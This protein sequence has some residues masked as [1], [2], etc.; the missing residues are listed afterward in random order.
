MARINLSLA[1]WVTRHPL[2]VILLFTVAAS[3]G[4]KYSIDHLRVDTDTAKMLSDELPFKQNLKRFEQLFPHDVNVILIALESSLPEVTETAT[5]RLGN[6]LSEKKKTI[7]SIYLPGEDPFFDRQGLLYLDKEQLQTLAD[8]LARAQPFIAKLYEDFSLGSF[9]QLLAK[10]L[11]LSEQQLPL[12]ITPML[13]EIRTAIEAAA[14][15]RPHLISWQKLM[16]NTKEGV[17]TTTRFVMVSPVL[18]FS[19]L[20]PA[21]EAIRTIH[22]AV[23]QISEI[24][25]IKVT[26]L[27]TGEPVLEHEEMT[28][29]THGTEWAGLVSMILICLS[30]VIG[31]RSVKL[32][33]ATL[34]T[35]VFG[36]IFSVT[37]AAFAVGSLN[38]I[39]IAFAVLYIGLGVDYATHLGLRYRE[40]ILEDTHFF[41][42][43]LH[44]LR[45]VS[46]S[47]MLCALTTALGMYAFIPTA[48][49]GISEL[50]IIA[51]T[52]MFIAVTVTLLLMPALL[53]LMPLKSAARWKQKSTLFFPP[54]LAA[55]PSRHATLIRS[56]A[57]L[58]CIAALGLL[59]GIQ[60]DFNPINLRDPNSESVIAFKK[61]LKGK[62]TS[63]MYL[64][65]LGENEAEVRL[66]K[67]RFES[68]EVVE[69][70]LSIFDFVPTEQDD[71]LAIIDE[72]ALLLG[73]QLEQPLQ[74]RPK[75]NQLPALQDFKR[76]LETALEKS[77]GDQKIAVEKLDLALDLFLQQCSKMDDA[78]CGK[79]VGRLQFSILGTFPRT[80]DKLRLGL[81]ASPFGLADLPES[82][83]E[84]WLSP[85]GI[86]RLDIY[87]AKDLNLLDN[88]REFATQVRAIYPS[89]T[90]LP[91]IYMDSMD[92][93]IDAFKQAFAMAVALITA[94]LFVLLRNGRDVFLVLLP[95]V[96]ASI[97]TGATTVLIGLPFNFANIIALPLL[98]GL[99]VDNGIHVVHRI[100]Q[101]SNPSMVLTTSTARGIFF[102]ALTTL[103]SFTSLAFISHKGVASMGQLLAI[104]VAWTLICTFFVL[105]AFVKPVQSNKEQST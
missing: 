68:L 66:L 4:L 39:S 92:A 105:P 80:L 54:D 51:G 33:L 32:M 27:I 44:S 6:I 38:M 67:N 91:V 49:K 10:A 64:T 11:L 3:F 24:D 53:V 61:L 59:C 17:G 79:K 84:R 55:L 20:L 86:F 99:G 16:M 19:K 52:S 25:G 48:Y 75:P 13:N 70:T 69:S 77:N 15:N 26:V 83:R 85:N 36:L 8:E 96:L 89:V 73:P 65:A 103:C 50:G 71:K 63:P 88:L 22:Q 18:D 14:E 47:L 72:M 7:K 94:L 2:W 102:S 76:A 1:R 29:I 30:L 35:L 58:F 95:L 87:P 5:E 37:F 34:I 101:L 93:V 100:H 57:L 74:I 31:F 41:D 81:E 56:F 90:G 9:L 82:L 104:G 12:E 40:Y 46:P 45:T 78:A 21:E 98:F 43:I 60:V 97:L 62:E 23:D 28:S 42:A